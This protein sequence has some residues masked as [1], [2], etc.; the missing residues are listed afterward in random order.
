MNSNTSSRLKPKKPTNSAFQNF[1]TVFQNFGSV[2]VWANESFEGCIRFQ[3]RT[4]LNKN[5]TKNQFKNI[6][7]Y[8]FV[9]YAGHYQVI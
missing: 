7:I 6:Y 4:M 5:Q 2:S 1:G 9:F 8:I 3:F